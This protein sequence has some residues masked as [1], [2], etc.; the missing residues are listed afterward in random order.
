MLTECNV[1]DPCTKI[2][3][4]ECLSAQSIWAQRTSIARKGGLYR[5]QPVLNILKSLPLTQ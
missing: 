3:V 2:K 5:L 4:S 1:S